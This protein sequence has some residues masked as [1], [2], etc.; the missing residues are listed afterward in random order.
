MAEVAPASLLVTSPYTSPRRSILL[1]LLLLLLLLFLL[2]LLGEGW[3]TGWLPEVRPE[4]PLPL[5]SSQSMGTTEKIATGSGAVTL[6]PF[7]SL[8][9]RLSKVHPV[10][11]W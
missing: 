7:H 11:V 3:C 6:N 9:A 8:W 10:A 1:L 5:P 2:L 4:R